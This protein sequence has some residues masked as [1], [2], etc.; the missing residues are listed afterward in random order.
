MQQVNVKLGVRKIVLPSAQIAD[1]SSARDAITQIGG[2]ICI[3]QKY[4]TN[5][6]RIDDD[7]A[8]MS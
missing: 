5:S 7:C 2:P 6:Y 8:G 4:F 1:M 3:T